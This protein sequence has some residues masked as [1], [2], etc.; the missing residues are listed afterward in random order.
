[1]P[2]PLVPFLAP[3]LRSLAC[4]ALFCAISSCGSGSEYL[5]AAGRLGAAVNTTAA[6]MPDDLGLGAA[7]CRRRAE[8]DFA[9]HA[10]EIP[11]P[12]LFEWGAGP[13]WA[14][15]YGNRSVDGVTKDTWAGQCR[16]FEDADQVF[17]KAMVILGAYGDALGALAASGNYDGAAVGGIASGAGALASAL[18]ATTLGADL[19]AIGGPL[20]AIASALTARITSGE[21]RTFIVNT[22]PSVGLVLKDLS[23]YVGSILVALLD[24]RSR[25]KTLL[26]TV[27]AKVT[28]EAA[29]AD[30]GAPAIDDRVVETR[31]LATFGY[32]Y[33]AHDVTVHGDHAEAL[34]KKLQAV[35]ADLD[36]AD[37]SLAAR[38]DPDLKGFGESMNALKKDTFRLTWGAW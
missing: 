17:E 36:R 8:L 13:G 2:R 18:G 26:R 1:M 29:S 12:A 11:Q 37:R 28:R 30:A 15:F 32:A 24:E 33:A 3:F 19:G 10:L 38:P 4:P 34:A 27:E 21:A 35:L 22:Q 9:Q 5:K 20:A 16:V 7:V 6:A 14:D 23:A 31:R 25:V